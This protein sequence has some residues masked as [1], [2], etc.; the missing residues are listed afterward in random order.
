MP[1]I[2][3]RKVEFG[4]SYRVQHE[5]GVVPG[6]QT[7]PR[8]GKQLYAYNAVILRDNVDTPALIIGGAERSIHLALCFAVPEVCHQG[9]DR[10]SRKT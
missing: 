1:Q 9:R 4:R 7:E 8:F 3:R 6:Y 5:E 10:R 2:A